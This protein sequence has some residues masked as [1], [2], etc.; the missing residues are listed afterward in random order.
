MV[1][2]GTRVYNIGRYIDVVQYVWSYS[3]RALLVRYQIASIHNSWL[4]NDKNNEGLGEPGR[5]QGIYN[6]AYGDDLIR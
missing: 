2:D 1:D 4:I 5:G 6:S 3:T